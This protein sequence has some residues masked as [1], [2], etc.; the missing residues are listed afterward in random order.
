[1]SLS[2]NYSSTI[3]KKWGA[4]VEG[5][6]LVELMI[7]L[8]IMAILAAIAIPS[9]NFYKAKATYSSM[10]ETLRSAEDWAERYYSQNDSYPSASCPAAVQGNATV[11]TTMDGVRVPAYM[12]VVVKPHTCGSFNTYLIGVKYI[13]S[14]GV[15]SGNTG[16][17]ATVWT[18][19]REGT[20]C[21]IQKVHCDIKEIS[22]CSETVPSGL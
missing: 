12:K 2:C 19:G 13:K 8:A 1:M 5:F 21:N 20:G 15:L 9:Y 11:C 10:M 6:T 22:H 14:N 3:G 17:N 4:E 16:L 7:A 18:Y